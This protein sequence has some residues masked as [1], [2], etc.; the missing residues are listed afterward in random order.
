MSAYRE[1][2][3]TLVELGPRYA[4]YFVALILWLGAVWLFWQSGVRD[5][6]DLAAEPVPW[7]VLVLGLSGAYC[8]VHWYVSRWAFG[9]DQIGILVASI[10]GDTH[11]AQQS[12]YI[13]EIYSLVSADPTLC[14][15]VKVRGLPTGWRLPLDPE[16]QHVEALR[17]GRRLG[18]SLVIRPVLTAGG[19]SPWVTIVDQPEF[20]H[21]QAPLGKLTRGQL[22]ELDK[23]PLPHNITLLARCALGLSFYRRF[24]Y[25]QAL[26]HLSHVLQAPGLP[27]A[28]PARPNLNFLLGNCLWCLRSAD[29]ASIL[30]RAI[31]AY[32][33]ALHEWDKECHPTEWAWTMNNRG[34]AY[35]QLPG[36]DRGANLREAIRCF[37]DALQVRTHDRFPTQWAMTMNNRGSAYR[38]LPG[39]DR[40]ANLREAIRCFDQAL[41]Q[42]TRKRYPTEWA[43]TMNNRGTAYLDLP[44]PDGA[45]NLCEAIRCFDQALKVHTRDRHPTDWAMTMSNRGN[46]YCNLP[47]PDRTANIQEA[48]RCFDE[49]LTVYTRDRYPTEWARTMNNRGNACAELPR[50]E[51]G[52]N[53]RE[54]IRCFDE[55][56]Q[57]RTRDRYPTQWASTMNNRGNA[58]LELVGPDRAANLCEAISCFEQAI[59]IFEEHGFTHYAEASRKNLF[60]AHQLLAQNEPPAPQ[61]D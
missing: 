53:L 46:A 47:G 20:P 54:A 30:P 36:P 37:D 24:H 7:V 38:Q 39:P 32:E 57:V 29:P 52:S 50:P 56:L 33:E 41:K 58:Y 23:L 48:I 17:L 61:V 4:P 44:G 1:I 19:H 8:F 3:G 18:A 25:N 2:R 22:Q 15:V 14:D 16:E 9:P 27:S 13:H 35:L 26:E 40:E 60:E 28:A 59:P 11:A 51:R 12:T 49:A 31:H 43:T 6:R 34:T 45:P 21:E 55:A 5:P 42:L 10:P